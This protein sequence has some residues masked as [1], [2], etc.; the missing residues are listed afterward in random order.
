MDIWNI[1][2]PLYNT[3]LTV[4]VIGTDYNTYTWTGEFSVQSKPHQIDS[5]DLSFSD[6]ETYDD[7]ELRI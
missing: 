7:G 5:Y 4:G 3:T 6:V 1:G 2:S